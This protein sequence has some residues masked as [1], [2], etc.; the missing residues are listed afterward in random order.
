MRAAE[1]LV[2]EPNSLE[3]EI[4]IEK[5]KRYKPTG[6]NQIPA[7]LIQAG[8]TALR[9][10]IHKLINSIRNKEEFR[11]QWKKSI[12]VPIYKNGNETPQKLQRD[13]TATNYI[14]N[15]TQYSCL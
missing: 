12:T 6:T 14:Q 3:A 13:I 1:S 7:E 2:P 5:L 4:A 15:L 9:S 10:K 11:Q 8:G